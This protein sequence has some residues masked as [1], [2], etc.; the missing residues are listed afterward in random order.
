MWH[1][2]PTPCRSRSLMHSSVTFRVVGVRSD[3][4]RV[5]LWDRLSS[6]AAHSM[7]RLLVS[8][9]RQVSVEQA[10]LVP[11]PTQPAGTPQP[12][13]YP[14][15]SAE[16]VVHGQYRVVPCVFCRS[17]W[18]E[19]LVGVSILSLGSEVGSLCPRCL[20]Y[21]PRQNA[22]W[23]GEYAELLRKSVSELTTPPNNG[24]PHPSNGATPPSIA[25]PSSSL[26]LQVRATVARVTET[27]RHIQ[28]TTA[29][30]RRGTRDL[31]HR[32]AHTRNLLAKLHLEGSVPDDE[33]LLAYVNQELARASGLMSLG[34]MLVKLPAWQTTVEKMMHSEQDHVASRFHLDA[35][36]IAQA[37]E[38]RYRE[39]LLASA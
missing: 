7:A 14:S 26:L 4:T 24:T 32:L 11:A 37:T 12:V 5:V 20:R 27:T 25:A 15:L 28:R 36:A 30:L 2:R 9:C 31:K 19:R 17:E 38:K 21:T 6:A 16:L 1:G 33:A 3:G 22:I 18:E 35:R 29:L 34:P 10:P 8:D 39:Y 23:L 13:V